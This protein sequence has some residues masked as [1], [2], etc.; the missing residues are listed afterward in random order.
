M[1]TA[2]TVDGLQASYGHVWVISP[3]LAG[4]RARH[5]TYDITVFAASTAELLVTLMEMAH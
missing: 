2:P 4:V 3:C 1:S 5:R